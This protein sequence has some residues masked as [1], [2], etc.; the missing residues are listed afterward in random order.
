M[1]TGLIKWIFEITVDIYMKIVTLYVN[2][3]FCNKI[4]LG[5]SV[6]INGICLTITEIDG[7]T[8]KFQITDETINK[9]NL[10]YINKCLTNI[11]L[12]VQYGDY[13]GGHLILGHIH[14]IGKIIS[15]DDRGN[16]WIS[17]SD[18]NNVVYK[19]SIAINGISLTVAE[20]KENSIRIALIPETIK[21]VAHMKVNDLVNI[22]FDNTVMLKDKEWMRIAIK[23][24]EKGRNTAPPNPWVGCV[25]V[26][27]NKLLGKGYHQKSGCPHAEINAIINCGEQTIEGATLY[28]TLEP[29]CSFP[30]KKMPPCVDT[31]I[32]NKISKV[33]IG[34]KDPNPLVSGKGVEILK[35]AGIE[36]LFQED[37]CKEI[38]DEVCYSLRQ[39]IYSKKTGLPF[40]TV[41]I[42]LSADGCYI[43]DEQSDKWITHH[44]SRLELYKLWA[45]SQAVII[46]G[47]TI[48]KD[49]CSLTSND[50]DFLNKSNDIFNESFNFKKV[51]FDGFSLVNT[52]SKIFDENCIIVTN[53]FKKWPPYLKCIENNT[54][55]DVLLYLAKLG[56]MHC[57]IEGGGNLHKS[58]L[59]TDLVNEIVIFRGS[60]LL[61]I[62][63][64]HWNVP[65]K[66][67]SLITAKIIEY[68]KVKNIMETYTILNNEILQEEKTEV[69]FDSI[70]NA[71]K[72][73]KEGGMVL[74]MDDEG[75]ENE[76]DLIVAASKI[77][78]S[79]LTE[80]INMT[81]GIICV[82]MERHW[83]KRLNLPL[84]TVT[85]TDNHETAFTI[86][87][88]S[89]MT[90]TG[91]SSKD[92]L[93]TI[94]AL[95]S[96]E[97]NPNDLRRPGHVY[98][99]ISKRSLKERKG[100][101]E[102][103]VTLCK[104]SDIYPRVA[105]IGELKNKDGTMKRRNDCFKYAKTNNIPIIT[106]DSLSKFD[107]SPKILAECDLTTESGIWKFVC[108]DSGK[109][110]C[111]H[112]VLIYGNIEE[113][114][115]EIT[116]RI[117]SDCFTGDVLKSLHCDCGLQKEK[118]IE[119]IVQKGKGIIIFP[120]SHEGRGIGIVEKVKSYELQKQG[121]DTFESN[122]ILGHDIDARTYDDINNIL[123]SL[124]ISNIV[125]LTENPNKIK[126]LGSKVVRTIPLIFSS[127]PN[128][129]KY[130]KDKKEY[131]STL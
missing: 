68:D 93:L 44:G 13:L 116:V 97:T 6:C 92:R 107:I 17:I 78:E 130:L 87:V 37:L 124:R 112:R 101:T 76:G 26:K 96:E 39:Y 43:D 72:V 51:I 117:H 126:E 52:E 63:S 89:K 70:E 94:K 30:N 28:V 34:V 22:E 40:C 105:V 71:I 125:L 62:D 75:R 74:V 41:K 5:D 83:A 110:D 1:F 88:D 2:E 47:N 84:M 58:F 3:D 65:Q 7:L 61:G 11:E 77:S 114:N 46:G 15:L 95:S 35:N 45:S 120:S 24:G 98:P 67:I 49:N 122:R 113:K 33:I 27:H 129:I 36:V 99:L 12:A 128:S 23:E 91:V 57:L 100:H 66:T 119:Y 20:I 18:V 29:C 54:I 8:C 131:F 9:T 85:N 42:A 53:D 55:K 10:L 79:Q 123:D 38:Y 90:G 31:I 25:I 48:Q 109:K 121:H 108:Y 32:K 82:P 80:M 4:K 118:A 86:S 60:K 21:R 106:V 103:G 69:A 56:V 16:L 64:Y 14:D 73:F 19:G 102:A 104:L 59:Q 50:S 115:D 81:T 127:N 111:P